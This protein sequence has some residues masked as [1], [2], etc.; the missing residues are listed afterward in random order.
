M[1]KVGF[2][3]GRALLCS[4]RQFWRGE[5]VALLLYLSWRR[6]LFGYSGISIN[7]CTIPPAYIPLN[8]GGPRLHL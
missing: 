1:L 8:T 2:F 3:L 4:A 6:D 7:K 5:D